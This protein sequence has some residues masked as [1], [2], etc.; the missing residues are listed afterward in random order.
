MFWGRDSRIW[1]WVT[2]EGD[3]A[4]HLW[5]SDTSEGEQGSRRGEAG[6]F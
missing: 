3:K 5:D 6:T 2:F 4:M 1:Q